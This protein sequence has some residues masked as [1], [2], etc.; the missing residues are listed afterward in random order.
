MAGHR[1]LSHG[2]SSLSSL[3]GGRGYGRDRRLSVGGTE[4]QSQKNNTSQPPPPHHHDYLAVSGDGLTRTKGPV[5]QSGNNW[6]KVKK[7][8]IIVI[9]VYEGIHL[10]KPRSAKVCKLSKKGG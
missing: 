9:I 6:L 1:V 8:E 2:A 10:I 4:S 5:T 3:R 7:S